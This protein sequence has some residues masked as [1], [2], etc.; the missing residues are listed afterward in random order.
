MEK[1]NGITSMKRDKLKELLCIGYYV[2]Y[3]ILSFGN[4]QPISLL[5]TNSVRIISRIFGL[6]IKNSS[7]RKSNFYNKIYNLI[8]FYRPKFLS[9]AMVDYRAIICKSKNSRYSE[10]NLIIIFDFFKEEKRNENKIN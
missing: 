1:Y 4:N 8:N 2:P 6:E 3:M 10:C 9:L 7:G 5:D